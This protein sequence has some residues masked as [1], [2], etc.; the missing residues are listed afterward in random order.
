MEGIDDVRQ[1]HLD[2]H[3]SEIQTRIFEARIQEPSR[4]THQA[5]LRV[6]DK[7]LSGVEA[8]RTCMKRTALLLPWEPGYSGGGDWYLSA[9]DEARLHA[10]LLEA[11]ENVQCMRT[12]DALNFASQLKE[13]RCEKAK[14]LLIL[15]LGMPALA[16][17]IKYA[18]PCPT[19]LRDFAARHELKICRPQD[20]EEARR[21]GCDTTAIGNSFMKVSHLIEG[22]DP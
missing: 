8:L 20:L 12:R 18:P 16:Q 10:Q 22:R 1:A 13:E 5:L 3:L 14:R 4:A 21:L 2:G 6:F 17:E 11:A 19:W 9:S 15:G 7:A